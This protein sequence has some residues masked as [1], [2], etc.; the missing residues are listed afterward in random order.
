MAKQHHPLDRYL[1][2]AGRSRREL[3]V[4]VGVTEASLSRIVNRKQNASLALVGRIVAATDG[5]VTFDDFLT[6][7]PSRETV[8]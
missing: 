3:A 8:A 4:E 1:K 5:S 2:H 7:S 6:T